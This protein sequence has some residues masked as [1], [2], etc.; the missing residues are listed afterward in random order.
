[1][2][3]QLSWTHYCELLR[4]KDKN[5]VDYY[6][7]ISINQNL[8]YR[9]LHK[10]IKDKEYERLPS[11]T[12]NKLNNNENLKISD[13]VKNPLLIKKK[14]GANH[15]SEKMLHN[16]ILEDISSFMKELGEGFSYIDSEYK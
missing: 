3:A 16:L 8:T 7:N 11:E 15:V 4:V 13:M 10:R 6:I 9:Q 12:K 5:A 2:T 1:M 14:Y